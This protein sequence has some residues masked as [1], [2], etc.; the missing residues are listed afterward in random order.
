MAWKLKLLK[1]ANSLTSNIDRLEPIMILATNQVKIILNKQSEDA[2][3]Q[4][5]E[6]K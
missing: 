6:G 2:L 4:V 3:K 1:V 5:C